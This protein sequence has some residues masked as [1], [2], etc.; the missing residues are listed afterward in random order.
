VKDQDFDRNARSLL[1]RRILEGS[2]DK[3]ID[4]APDFRNGAPGPLTVQI[5][6]ILR[7]HAALW[8]NDMR[9]HQQLGVAMDGKAAWLLHMREADAEIQRFIAGH[10]LTTGQAA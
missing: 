1:M 2:P 9:E 3:S 6:K 5:S 8:A 10:R 7:A 4:Y